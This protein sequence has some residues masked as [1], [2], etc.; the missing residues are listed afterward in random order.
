[1]IS[2][3][4]RRFWIFLILV[5]LYAIAGYFVVPPIVRTQLEKR[6]SAELGRRVSIGAVKVDPFAL[7]ASLNGVQIMRADGV[8]PF[9]AWRRLYVNFDPLNSLR[10]EAWVL[11]EI[12]LEDFRGMVDIDEQG[13]LSVADLVEKL[14]ERRGAPAEPGTTPAQR[15]RAWR[16]SRLNVTG[17]QVEFVD[18][19][20]ADVFRTLIGPVNLTLLEFRTAGGHGAPYR[21]EA[22]SESGERL[23]WIGSLTAKPFTST[24]EWRIEN[25]LLSKYAPYFEDRLN[26]L[27]TSGK[28]TMSG[29]YDVSLAPDDRRLQLSEGAAQLTKLKLVERANGQPVLEIAQAE[30]TGLLA[31]GVER[32]VSLGTV[33]FSEGQLA[34]RRETDG[35]LNLAALLQPPATRRPAPPRPRA[36]ATEESNQDAW[37]VTAAEVGLRNFLVRWQDATTPRPV[38]LELTG[39][40]ATLKEWT[41]A[42]G[43]AVPVEASFGLNPQGTARARGEL[44]MQPLRLNLDVELAWIPLPAFSGYL[45]G[46]MPLRLSQGV[47]SVKG[48]VLLSPGIA[49]PEMRFTGGGRMEQVLLTG[50]AQDDELGGFSNLAANDVTITNTPRLSVSLGTMSLSAPFVRAVIDESGRLNLAQLSGGKPAPPPAPALAVAEAEPPAVPLD[51]SVGRFTLDGGEVT[52]SDLSLQPPVQLTLSQIGGTVQNVSSRNPARGE[53]DLRALVEG[54]SPLLARGRFN[55]FAA[56]PFADL[57]I[58]AKSVDLA[59]AG[60]YVAKYA[61]HEL[62]GGALFLNADAKLV[63]QTLDIHSRLRLDQFTLG[64][65]TP[66]PD[67][68]KLPVRLGVALLKDAKGQI[69]LEVPVQGSLND[70]RFQPGAAVSQVVTNM[71]AKAATA[72]F[73]LIGAMFGGGGEELRFQDFP[74]GEATPTPQSRERLATLQRAMMERP[75]LGLQLEPSYDPAELYELKRKTLEG[76]IRQRVWDKLK[77]VDANLPPIDQLL[78][79]SSNRADVVTAMFDERFGSPRRAPPVVSVAPPP[80]TTAPPAPADAGAAA[81]SATTSAAPPTKPPATVEPRERST[82]KPGLIRRAWNLATLKGVR[83]RLLGDDEEATAASPPPTFTPPAPA[84]PPVVSSPIAQHP[85]GPAEAEPA[86]QV[87]GPLD[88][89]LSEMEQRLIDAMPLGPDDLMRLAE[90]RAQRVKALLTEGGKVDPGRVQ[91]VRV[92]PESAAKGARITLHLQ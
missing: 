66:N 89:S 71:L 6:L 47:A 92:K 74:L 75:S 8:E 36:G 78:I 70:P 15:G 62:A 19:S 13:A 3:G 63:D 52:F 79:S 33:R 9:A 81:D 31:D 10:G 87:R 45:E 85:P 68:L 25:V 51:L 90:A 38:Q 4:R 86:A 67:A 39:F 34:A 82:E 2:R 61:G 29:R 65:P 43:A 42:A 20:R 84:P 77:A 41:T 16:F 18:R 48:R 64:R 57:V 40:D 24:G 49:G 32:R 58:E 21:F 27:L 73:A 88:V 50:T 5:G 59:P 7:S 53:A 14:A 17:A 26:I 23:N 54:E 1:M 12:T 91:I 46:A 55:P 37:E 69:E 56:K 44:V 28:L 60:P 80:A 11:G 76:V 72:P 35:R 83:D 30:L 22:R